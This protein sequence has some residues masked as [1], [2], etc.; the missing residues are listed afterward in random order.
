[1][2]VTGADAAS[3]YKPPQASCP[4]PNPISQM[5]MDAEADV[6]SMFN[7]ASTGTSPTKPPPPSSSAFHQFRVDG[8]GD[9]DTCPV[10]GKSEP[11]LPWN[12]TIAERSD[13]SGDEEEQEQHR[14]DEDDETEVVENNNNNNKFKSQL[15]D[16]WLVPFSLLNTEFYFRLLRSFERQHDG[17]GTSQTGS[18]FLILFFVSFVRYF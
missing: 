5:E 3:T 14:V 10:A 16:G 2:N 13:G 18:F 12:K 17:N 1:M 15:V 7:S 9:A 6:D 8:S 4:S 11:K